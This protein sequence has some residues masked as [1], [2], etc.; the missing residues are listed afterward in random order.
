MSRSTRIAATLTEG[1]IALV[2]GL[3]VLALVAELASRASH[4][5]VRS[6]ERVD[7]RHRTARAF[8]SMRVALVDAWHFHTADDARSVIFETPAG[9]GKLSWDP[10]AGRLLLR[11]AGEE[12]ETVLVDRDVVDFAVAPRALGVLAIGLELARPSGPTRAAGRTAPGRVVHEILLPSIAL[13][14]PAIPW[15]RQ[16]EPGTALSPSY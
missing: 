4:V 5:F 13:R 15:V 6:E 9:V 16:L 1:L 14:S 7:A 12:R 11:R 2:V 10:A 3:L 8:S